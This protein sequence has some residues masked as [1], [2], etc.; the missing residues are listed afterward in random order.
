MVSRR[1]FLLGLGGLVT[2]AFVK[3]A[4]YHIVETQTPLLLYPGRTEETLYVYDWFSCGD[5]YQ[6]AL[7]IMH[8][9][10]PGGRWT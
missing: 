3:R 10:S 9:S 2:S 8:W 6:L 5:S 1:S 7:I 4:T